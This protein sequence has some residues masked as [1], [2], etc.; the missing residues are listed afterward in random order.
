M[1]LIRSIKS[2]LVRL[3]PDRIYLKR[4]YQRKFGKRLDLKNP[5]YFNEKINWL[6]LHDRNPLYSTMVDKYAV[7]DFLKKTVGGQYV[8]PCYGVWDTFD[9]I[10]VESLPE[11]F[12][13]KATHDSGTIYICHNKSDFYKKS[14]EVRKK[15]TTALSHNYYWNFREWVYKD[16]KPRIIAEKL[17]ID[18]GS[19]WLTDYKFLCFGGEPK[20]VYIGKDKAEHA[21]NDFYDMDFNRLNLHF[22]DP[23]SDF[24]WEKPSQFEEM[25]ALSRKLSAG[26]RFL[27]CDFYIINNQVY[28]G[29]L[30][31][32]QNAAMSHISS[33]EWDLRLASWID[34]S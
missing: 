3:M 5:K 23:N 11:Q 10:D 27:R 4:Q 20:I 12:V 25:K 32:Y 1:S 24:F 26:T 6:K 21:T 16:V 34:I 28:V 19:Q 8:I 31:F 22:K 29:E 2:R 9:S 30:T 14:G 33:E 13:L 17:L 18:D 15:F 7:K